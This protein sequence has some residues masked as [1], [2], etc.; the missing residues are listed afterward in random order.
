MRSSIIAVLTAFIF[1]LISPHSAEAAQTL[2]GVLDVGDPIWTRVFGANVGLNCDATSSVSST[3]V[4]IPYDTHR[5]VLGSVENFTAEIVA[6]AGTDVSDPYI[7]LYCDPF[8]PM[9]PESNLVAIDNDGGAGFLSAFTDGDGLAL[10]VGQVY[11]LVVSLFSSG[12]IGGG[13]YE[14]SLGGSAFASTVT[15]EKTDMFLIDTDMIWM[16]GRTSATESHIPC[17][18]RMTALR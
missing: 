15:V 5:I 3:G 10:N 13:N 2:N 9:N 1:A 14:L 11:V 4:D 12:G 7:F 16:D 6:G 17:R 8:D 18:S